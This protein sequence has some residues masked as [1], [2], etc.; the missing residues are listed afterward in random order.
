MTL[1]FSDAHLKPGQEGRTHRQALIDFLRA[2]RE[3]YGWN[4]LVCLGDLFD[5]WFEYRHACFSGYFDVLRAFADLRDAGV[6][7]FLVCGNHDFWVGPFLEREIGFNVC[8]GTLTMRLG[9]HRALLF[10]GDGVDPAD[11]AYRVYRRVARHPVATGMFRLLHPDFAMALARRVSH[12]SRRLFSDPDPSEGRQARVL[13]EHARAL[14]AA[15]EAELVACGHAHAPALETW[16]CP[17][18]EG[19]YLNTG[20]WLRQCTAAVWTGGRLALLRQGEEQVSVP[21]PGA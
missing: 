15:G 13:R 17:A 2:S 12:G 16:P 5:F 21:L 8:R 14:L 19:I 7:L 4:R 1:F 9:R 18:G 6:E 20:E 3:R 10:H 11:R